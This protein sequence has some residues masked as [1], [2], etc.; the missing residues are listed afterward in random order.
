MG[1]MRKIGQHAT[2]VTTVDGWTRVGYHSTCVIR[3]NDEQIILDT[4]GLD[5]H[6][7]KA[8]MN[9]ASNQFDLGLKVYAEKGVWWVAMNRDWDSR[10]LFH[11]G[12]VIDR[13]TGKEV[14]NV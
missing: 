1:Q 2:T 7:T 3:W 13:K 9:Q 5:S 6:T 8:R 12:M 10:I 11:N 14:E 4:G